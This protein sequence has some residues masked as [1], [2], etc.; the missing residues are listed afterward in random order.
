M[1]TLKNNI[2]IGLLED[3]PFF[4]DVV[5]TFLEHEKGWKVKV[6]AATTK[7]KKETEMPDIFVFDYM[8]AVD[9]VSSTSKKALNWM[10]TQYPE[11]PIIYFTNYKDMDTAIDLLKEGASDFLLKDEN[12]LFELIASIKDALSIRYLREKTENIDTKMLT[13]FTRFAFVSGMLLTI[14]LLL[15]LFTE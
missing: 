13:L 11:I 2:K 10:V 4:A 7:I 3:D 12:N 5:K 6:Y 9:D 15:L 14:G 8:M 1:K